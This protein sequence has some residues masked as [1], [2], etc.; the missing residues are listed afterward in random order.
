MNYEPYSCCLTFRGSSILTASRN[1]A[2]STHKTA[3][4]RMEE[5]TLCTAQWH[6]LHSIF[7]S[8]SCCVHTWGYA[9]KPV[10][11]THT[12]FRSVL[13]SDSLKLSRN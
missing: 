13:Q 6:I 4:N 9:Q 12:D 7:P 1:V 8:N 11:L 3:L 2:S 10:T 5:A